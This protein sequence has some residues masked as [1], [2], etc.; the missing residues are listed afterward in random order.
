MT[1][2]L[3]NPNLQSAV[4]V[5]PVDTVRAVI[6]SIETQAGAYKV[7]DTLSLTVKFSEVVDFEVEPQNGPT[8]FLNNGEQA[9]YVAGSGS[10]TWTFAYTFGEGDATNNPL[11]VLAFL[12][13]DAK[14]IDAASNA[15]H[16]RLHSTNRLDQ[17]VIIDGDAPVVSTFSAVAGHYGVDDVLW[18]KCSPQ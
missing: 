6:E 7:G 3:G 17:A 15:L 4:L 11:Q 10:D 2:V 13:N 16:P 14:M 1:D 9:Q 5:Q 12:E 8:L 18:I